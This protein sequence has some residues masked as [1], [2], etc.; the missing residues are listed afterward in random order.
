[1]MIRDFWPTYILGF[2][3][4]ISSLSCFG[5]RHVLFAAPVRLSRRSHGKGRAL[6][7]FEVMEEK[8][9]RIIMTPGMI[10]AWILSVS[11]MARSG[12]EAAGRWLHAKLFLVVVLSGYHGFLAATRKFLTGSLP[13][14]AVYRMIN[15]VPPILTFSLSYWWW[16]NR[17]GAACQF[18]PLAYNEVPTKVGF[19]RPGLMAALHFREISLPAAPMRCSYGPDQ[20]ARAEKQIPDRT[21]GFC[22]KP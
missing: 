15:E 5:W 3:L 16:Y 11:L 17:L 1:M 13:P 19:D 9:L 18:F 21:L 4:P 10:V 20:T 2:W 14:I 8:L 12:F 7:G 22:R 6:S